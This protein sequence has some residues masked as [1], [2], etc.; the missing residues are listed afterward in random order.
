MVA[1]DNITGYPTRCWFVLGPYEA[2]D[3]Y[4][5]ATASTD[6]SGPLTMVIKAGNFTMVSN[7]AIPPKTHA[8]LV[9]W[10]NLSSGEQ[11]GIVV[12]VAGTLL[13]LLGGI[14]LVARRRSRWLEDPL[15]P[16]YRGLFVAEPD[17]TVTYRP[18]ERFQI[19]AAW[20]RPTHSKTEMVLAGPSSN[21]L[22]HELEERR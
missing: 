1:Q 15:N 13:A 7:T 12:G 21:P 16:S 8:Q 9:V 5:D 2:Q 22:L 18:W 14:I 20:H 6:D 19:D 4:S 10:I 11:A 3:L 17:G